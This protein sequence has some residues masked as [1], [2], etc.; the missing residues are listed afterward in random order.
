MNPKYE[1]CPGNAPGDFY[2]AAGACVSCVLRGDGSEEDGELMDLSG[3]P[4][5]IHCRFHRQPATPDEVQIAC[6]AVRNCTAEAV[7]YAGKDKT[8]LDRINRP[9]SCDVMPR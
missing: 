2:V 8:I 7:R 4:G 1:P 6:Q 3:A 9:E 5:R